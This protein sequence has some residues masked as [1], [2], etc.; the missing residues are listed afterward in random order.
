MA[1][2]HVNPATPT[3]RSPGVLSDAKDAVLI[4]GGGYTGKRFAAA[5]AQRGVRTTVTHRKPR[6]GV[7]SY[8]WLRFDPEEG[9]IPSANKLK[10][11][12]HVLVTIPPD[13]DGHDPVLR[14][15]S[16]QL[17]RLPVRWLGYLSTTG[18]Y[19]DQRGGWV[20]ET[21]PTNANLPRSRARLACESAWRRT[22]LPLQVIRL[23]AIYGPQRTPFAK[24]INGS[25]RLI[26]KPAQVF[27]RIHVDDIVGA[28]LH[29]IDLP[30]ADR[31]KQ[32][33]VADDCPCPSSETLGYAAYLLG[34]KLPKLERFATAQGSMG[35]MASGFWN[36]NR[37]VSNHLLCRGLG[38]S[39]RF[40]SYREGY[41]ACLLEEFPR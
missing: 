34:R 7:Q 15:L 13:K 26:H 31:P 24:L 14:H 18:V 21:S 22:G 41:L 33:N 8:N 5:M 4:L 20:D 37:R 2:S 25:A 11:I 10:G 38:Y 36:E 39:L 29:C 35:Q 1:L 28:L 40:P 12:T 9:C 32:L 27:C 16:G 19:G 30:A 6:Q 23:P 17:S 3:T